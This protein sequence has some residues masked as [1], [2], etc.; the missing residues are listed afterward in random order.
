MAAMEVAAQLAHQILDVGA[1][2]RRFRAVLLLEREGRV[3][4]G[5]A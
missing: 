5:L 1:H 4:D 2:D 3:R